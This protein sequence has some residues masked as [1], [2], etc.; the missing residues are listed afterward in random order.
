M[1]IS[2]PSRHNIQGHILAGG[3]ATRMQGEDKGLLALNGKPLV[4]NVIERL[5]PQVA[6][7]CISANR[8]IKQY[9]Q[10]GL[11]VITDSLTGFLGPLAGI[12]AALLVCEQEWLVT[13][14]VDCPFLAADLV[15]RL[16]AAAMR[17]KRPIAVVHDGS[18]LQPTFCLLHQS[19]TENLQQYLQQGGRKTGEWLQQHDPALADFADKSEAFININSLADLTQAEKQL[20]HAD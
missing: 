2:P 8:H 18:A 20:T 16:S 14:P 17:N 9:Q 15:S 1:T 13:V 4:A 12:H 5:R 6:G 11:P 7:I 19:L 3:R 10:Y